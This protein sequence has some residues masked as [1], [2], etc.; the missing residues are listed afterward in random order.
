MKLDDLAL[1]C[2]AL[3]SLVVLLAVSAVWLLKDMGV[4]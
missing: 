1:G 4:M 3:V 2:L